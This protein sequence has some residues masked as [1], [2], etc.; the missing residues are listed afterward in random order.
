[1]PVS[2]TAS[3]RSG[4]QKWLAEMAGRNGW[5]KWLAEMAGAVSWWDWHREG[6]ER[7]KRG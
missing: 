1:L 2:G 6:K 7:I 3:V 5:Q 4:W